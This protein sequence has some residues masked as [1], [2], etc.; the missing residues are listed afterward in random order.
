M[1]R[2]SA[3]PSPTRLLGALLLAVWP[4]AAWPQSGVLRGT[5]VAGETGAA[6]PGANVA[7]LSGAYERATT[8]SLGGGFEVRGLPSG[9]YRVTV[10]YVGFERRVIESVELRAGEARSLRV[11]LAPSEIR[12]NPVTVSASRRAERAIEAPAAVHAVSRNDIVARPALTAIEHLQAVPALDIINTGINGSRWALRGFNQSFSSRLLTLCDHRIANLPGLRLNNPE[13]VP[14]SGEDLERIEVLEGPGS[15]LYGPN[16]AG[17][18]VH[19]LT[20][21]PFDAPGTTVSVGTGERDL[22]LASFRHAGTPAG[23][24]GY[25]LSGA[26]HQGTD[27]AFDDPAEPDTLT[28]GRDSP[29][30]RTV[31]SQPFLNDRD[32]DTSKLTVDG[33]VD[34]R[35]AEKVT[36]VLAAGYSRVDEIALTSTGSSR[37]DGW[38]LGYGQG[39][40]FYGNL[41]AQA[42]FNRNN[43]GDSYNLRTG[44]ILLDNSTQFVT[45]VQH[46]VTVAGGR[47][48]FD[49]GI[50]VLLT[51]PDSRGTIYGRN[52]EDDDLDEVGYYLQSETDLSARFKLLAAGRIDHNNRLPDAVLSPRAALLFRPAANHTVRLTYN[53]AFEMPPA[54]E[55]YADLNLVPATAANPYAIR[56][57][58]VPSDGGFTFRRD[59]GGGLGGLYMHSPFT[60]LQQGGRA[61]ELPADATLRWDAIVAILAAS[62]VDLSAVPAPQAEQVATLLKEYSARTNAFEDISPADVVDIAPLES[63]RTSTF[64]AGYK[65]LMR[66]DLFVT[67]NAYYERNANFSV[68]NVIT[69][70]A[71]LD[72]VSLRAYLET[73]MS[74]AQ[75]AGLAAAIGGIPV[76]TL[77][78]RE[79]DPADL[80]LSSRQFGAVSHVGLELGAWYY[81]AGPWTVS[82]NYSYLSETLF[83]R[84]AGWPDDIGLNAP[85]HKAAASLGYANPARGVDANLRGRYVGGFR[86]LDILG[87]GRVEAYAVADLVLGYSFRE[88]PVT[89]SL[90]VQNLLGNRH[91][92]YIRVPQIGRLGILRLTYSLR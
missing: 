56:I 69:P 15:A 11:A 36:A 13:L 27:W 81:P 1:T 55:L 74:P 18:V 35:P 86:V 48:R 83:E 66:R 89:V 25:K 47:Q 58:G 17:G 43:A 46:A 30:G 20:R 68:F 14:P 23:T 38:S 10:S 33:R 21:S 79:G 85:T 92:E 34:Y 90:S 24:I 82:G 76:G 54:V 77:S 73:W 78:P 29:E 72:P 39:R 50:D 44:N 16:A 45:Q 51:R 71:F 19:Y 91:R 57:L 87:P 75:A 26:Y 84:K 40:L 3:V 22:R 2:G 12:M 52:E 37:L 64:E 70:S 41:F 42:F 4:A 8:A 88:A 65:G 63:R 32:Y 31:L 67:A 9:T 80:L 61:A 5:V 49:Y 53:R 59:A 62:G 60:P 7:L 6:L 28:L